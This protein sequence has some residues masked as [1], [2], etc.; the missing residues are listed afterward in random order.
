MKSILFLALFLFISCETNKES[1][2]T[3]AFYKCLLLDSD[4]VY[5]HLN[6]LIQAVKSL[7]PI[8]FAESIS[9]IIP[10]ITTEVNRCK[11]EV[12]QNVDDDIVLKSSDSSAGGNTIAEFFKALLK[13]VTTYIIPFLNSLGFDLKKICNSAFPDSFICELLE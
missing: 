12:K 7:D 2:E 4:T 13:A 9:T 5:D 10:A 6:S 8:K 11:K 3:I 1:E